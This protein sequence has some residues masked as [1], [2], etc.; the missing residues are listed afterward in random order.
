MN[1]NI[2][3][4]KKNIYNKKDYKNF[5]IQKLTLKNFRNHGILNLNLKNSSI[6]IYGENGCGK[7]N[8][9]EAISLL[10]QGKGL[11]KASI[12]NFL[13]QEETF[14]D[15][16]KVWGI[17]VDFVGPNGKFNI[18]TGLYKTSSKN[19]RIARVNSDYAP[20][21]SLGKI[22]NLSWITPQLCVLF[23]SSM[24]EKRR[25]IDRLTS[26]ID[27]LHLNRVYRYEKLLRQRNK[28]LMKSNFDHTWLDTIEFQISELSIAITARRLD[29]IDE[30][31][32]LYK[33]EL[34]NNSLTE[35][36]PSADIVISGKIESLLIEKPAAE[37]EDYIKAEL[38]KSRY[39]Y[40][41]F[42][43]GPNNAS[44]EI[45]NKK[46]KKNLDI[47]STGE[48]KLLLISIVLSHARMLHKKFNMAPILLLDDIIEHLDKEYRTALF[49]ETSRHDAQSWFTSTS[50]DAFSDFPG[51]IDKINLPKI[52][53]SFDGNYHYR[54]G[55]I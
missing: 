27:S 6:L 32:N 12:E 22:L 18:G 23:L 38:K 39:N 44:I 46:N 10:S 15:Q 28:I 4:F 31:E 45:F 37:V 40:D 19:S 54:N 11:R 20:L 47:S 49:L 8:I 26:S 9:L 33:T 41:L 14:N 16:H 53:E 24:S 21:N 34:K 43:P 52:K 2:L 55:D 17:N 29:L 35:Y 13:I 51:F 5:Y 48:Q 1:N 3:N 25:F 42:I 50:K 7:T 30:L 36:F